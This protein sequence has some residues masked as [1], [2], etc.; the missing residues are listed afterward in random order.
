MIK[1]RISK[2]TGLV[3]CQTAAS[4]NALHTGS[5]KIVHKSP[6]TNRGRTSI[7]TISRSSGELSYNQVHDKTMALPIP[8]TEFG[9]TKYDHQRQNVYGATEPRVIFKLPDNRRPSTVFQSTLRERIKGSPRFPHR[10]APTSS[11]SALV[12]DKYDDPDDD[13]GKT[14]FFYV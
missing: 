9:M 3:S 14:V 10:I 4:C 2:L 5:S 6:L 7:N 8:M 12:N 1:K 13:Y 11:L